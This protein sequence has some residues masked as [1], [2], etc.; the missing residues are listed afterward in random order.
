MSK[1]PLLICLLIGAT[2]RL[3]ETT[4]ILEGASG[5]ICVILESQ[6]PLTLGFNVAITLII[7]SNTAGRHIKQYQRY[8][9]PCAKFF[10]QLFRM[11]SCLL[12]YKTSF[13]LLK[14]WLI[15]T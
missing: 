8:M 15:P 14:V 6:N 10:F 13:S 12:N 7:T 4:P 1:K 5:E 3:L 9:F 2:V 11:T